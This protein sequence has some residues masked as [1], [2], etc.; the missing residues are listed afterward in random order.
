M[1]QGRGEIEAPLH[2]AR[3]RADAPVAGA[4][5]AHAVEQRVR[6]LA[7]ALAG[8]GVQGRLELEQLAA[9]HQRV[10]RRLLERHTDLATHR[11]G[12]SDHVM[13]G[14]PCLSAG[15]GEE[16]GQHPDGRGLPGAVRPQ[17]AID[18]PF[19]DGQVDAIDGLDAA[20]ELASKLLRLDCGHGARDDNRRP[21]PAPEFRHTVRRPTPNSHTPGDALG[22]LHLCVLGLAF[23]TTKG[24]ALR[25]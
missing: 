18:L 23:G 13:T 8:D 19:R 17:E 10:E 9:G 11:A 14:D 21:G 24:F 22:T 6:Q 4:R 7:P 12:F 2:P 20:L 3:V 25:P 16:R 1:D 5:Q 15:W